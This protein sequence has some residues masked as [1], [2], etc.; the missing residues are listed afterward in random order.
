MDIRWLYTV[1][2]ITRDDTQV[3]VA[4]TILILMLSLQLLSKLFGTK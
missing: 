3:Q 4:G 1:A 2:C